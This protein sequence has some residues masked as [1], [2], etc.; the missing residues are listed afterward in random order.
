MRQQQLLGSD[1]QTETEE[2]CFPCSP[3]SNNE[4]EQCFLCSI[5]SGS[6]IRSS[7]EYKKVFL[8]QFSGEEQEVGVRQPPACES[9]VQLNLEMATRRPVSEQ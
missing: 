1:V 4:E 7:H 3:L 8:R 5:C 6:I 9:K 2:W